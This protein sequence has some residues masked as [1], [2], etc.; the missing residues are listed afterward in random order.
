MRLLPHRRAEIPT[1]EVRPGAEAYV[2]GDGETGVLLCHGFTGSPASLRPWAEH[3]VR[4][5]FRVS[6][7]R[8]PGHG[9]SWQELNQTGWPDWYA[10]VERALGELTAQCRTVAVGGLSMGGALALRLAEL[11]DDRI[12]GL[13]LVNPAL[14]LTDA[15]LAVLPVLKH[16]TPS[17]AGITNDIARPFSDEIGYDR[18]PLKALASMLELW[19]ITIA[20]LQRVRQPILLFR[21]VHDHVVDP[22]SARILHERAQAPITERLLQQ[23]FHVATLD[24]DAEEIFTGSAEFI[25][26]LPGTVG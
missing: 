19:E 11:H 5:G 26:A 14:H 20:R 9:T 15:R 4:G 7:P 23:S 16:L 12:A 24:Y 1:T 2:G 18:T 22:A 13:V 10:T 3:L 8:L 21:S 25:R 17:V 6:V